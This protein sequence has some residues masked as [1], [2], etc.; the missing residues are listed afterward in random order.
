MSRYDGIYPVLKSLLLQDKYS[1]LTI[2]CGGQEFKAHRAIVC[3]QS[4]FF[5]AACDSG[6]KV[7]TIISTLG[8]S[9]YPPASVLTTNLRNP[10]LESLNFQRIILT[11]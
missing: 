7:G 6:L 4:S 1:D 3:P 5:A 2:I 8:C 10:Q 9:F 11:F